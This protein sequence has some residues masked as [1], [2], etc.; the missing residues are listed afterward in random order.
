MTTS[1]LRRLNIL[2]GMFKIKAFFTITLFDRYIW[3]LVF[4]SFH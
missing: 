4:Y 1:V 2:C 3:V